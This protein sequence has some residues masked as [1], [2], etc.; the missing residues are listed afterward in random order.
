MTHWFAFNPTE[1]NLLANSW[2]L[3]KI[4]HPQVNQMTQFL[5]YF[6]TEFMK[7]WPY[8]TP[9]MFSEHNPRTMKYLETILYIFA[10]KLGHFKSRLGG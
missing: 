10:V 7:L 5:S 2:Q 3:V 1:A 6:W 9:V 4:L 8:S